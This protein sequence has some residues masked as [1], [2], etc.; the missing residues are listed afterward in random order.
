M[1]RFL[2]DELAG[3]KPYK[4]PAELAKIKLNTNEA[5]IRPPKAVL[6]AICEAAQTM[7]FNRYPDPVLTDLRAAIADRL[8]LSP[9]NV[10]IGNGSN[11]IVRHL[12]MAYAGPGRKIAVFPPSYQVYEV[13]ASVSGTDVVR[14][15]RA[16]DFNIDDRAIR[17]AEACGAELLFLCNPNNPTGTLIPMNVVEELARRVSGLLVVDEAYIEFSGADSVELIKRND[18]VALLRTFS[19][20][21]GLAGLRIG[22]LLGS[23]EVVQGLQ[24]VQLPYHVNGLSQLAGATAMNATDEY[25]SMREELIASRE[26]VASEIAGLPE[27]KVYP[28]ASN[29]ILFETT[30]PAGVL[31]EGLTKRDV[32]IRIYPGVP[33]FEN[34]GRVTVGTPEECEEFLKALRSVLSEAIG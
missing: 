29:F 33:G 26:R 27:V 20:A 24:I 10:A 32:L 4:V 31:F 21:Y 25:T 34:S 3:F 12:F 19:K 30:I 22:Y 6:D 23:T 15:A 9:D 17:E 14:I 1:N 16:E 13:V 2:R 11:E 18:N 8:G 7:H 5:P 28:S